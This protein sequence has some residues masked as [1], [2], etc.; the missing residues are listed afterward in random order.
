MHGGSGEDGWIGGNGVGDGDRAC[1]GLISLHPLYSGDIFFERRFAPH[2]FSRTR[3]RSSHFR[4]II[5]TVL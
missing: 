3:T 4:K 5:L 2:K 1:E